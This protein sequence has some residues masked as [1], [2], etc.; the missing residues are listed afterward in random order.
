MKRR[1]RLAAGFRR[2]LA[3]CVMS[4]SLILPTFTLAQDSSVLTVASPAGFPDLDPA[5]SFSNDGAVLANAYET[6]TRYVPAPDGGEPKIEPV[7]ATEWSASENGLTWTFKLREGVT[8]SDGEPLTAAAVKASIN[9][10]ISV[11]GGAAFI[12]WP[13]D[14]I[15]TPDELTVVMNLNTPQPMD[16]IAASGYA[17]WIISPNATNKNNAWFNEGNSAGTGPYVI[18]RYDPGQR[19]VM[20]R[21]KN[22]R[23]GYE[24]GQFDKVI[25]EVV[26]DPVLMR[27]MI[28]S[29]KADMISNPGYEHLDALDTR[30]DVT[31]VSKASF[32]TLFGLY[33]LKKPPLDD[34]R[35]RQALSLAFPYNEVIASGTNGL[36]QRAMGVVPRGIWGHDAQA[37]V[38][39]LDLE[40]A[41]T[42]LK[43]AGVTELELTMTH[44]AGDALQS[45][46]GELWRANL[47]SVGVT[48]NLQPMTWD[49]QWALGKSDA[50]A[51]QD[52]FVMYWW[53]TFMTPYDYLINL[54]HTEPSPNFNLGYYSNAD[55]DNRIDDAHEL[56]G[57]DRASSAAA[58]VEA[59]RMIIEDAA[60]VFMLD[61]PGVHVLR[62]DVVGFVDNPAY[63]YVPIA[64]EMSR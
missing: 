14:N 16:I 17:A 25:F 20:A 2:R 52:I 38:P 15:T 23:G 50:T 6:L 29:G 53:P 13:L 51:A 24:D 43:D 45:L 41:A 31:V 3:A 27:Q 22:Y 5:T 49:A 48:L 40:Q 64:G 4:A 46:A 55:F 33:N 36:G 42:L 30:D 7:L 21:H 54:F 9:R 56:S 60:A 8:F 35:V 47:A 19:V 1:Q 39:S 59:Q 61:V 18:E 12:W 11:G 28:E 10:T 37:P 57:V 62:S 63:R 44:G 32:Q 58:F 26:E 34:R